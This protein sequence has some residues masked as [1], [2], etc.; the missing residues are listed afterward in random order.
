MSTPTCPR[1]VETIC[2]HCG[3]SCAGIQTWLGWAA[4]CVCVR[5]AQ[6]IYCAKYRADD[7]GPVPEPARHLIGLLDDEVL[8]LRREI[9][10]LRADRDA[11]RRMVKP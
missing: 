4:T 5:K 11:L 7:D 8:R 9:R 3:A 6:E 2:P 1:F 10:A